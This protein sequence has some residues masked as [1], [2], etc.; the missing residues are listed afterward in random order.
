MGH[1]FLMNPF[2]KYRGIK[3]NGSFIP[4]AKIKAGDYPLP[5]NSN[6]AA[7]IQ[8]AEELFD[9]ADTIGVKTSGSTGDPKLFTFPKSALEQSAKATIS[10][11]NLLP[12]SRAALALPMDYIAAKMMVTR[13]VVGGFNIDVAQPSATPL[14]EGAQP[15]FIPV[16]PHQM[17]EIIA[18]QN[19]LLQRQTTFL[20]GGGPID[21]RLKA[22]L[23]ERQIT[24]YASFGMTE[25][26]SHFALAAINEEPLI[27]KPLPGVKIKQSEI[28]A[29]AVKWPGITGDWL[30]TNDLVEIRNGGFKWLGRSDFL[31]NSGG[32]KIIPEQ[33]ESEL[34][35]HLDS[36]FFIHGVPD[37]VLG[38]KAVLFIEGEKG[39][40][41]D[42]LDRV[43]WQS[44][45]H[46]PK[47][48]MYIPQF[49]RTE[50]GKIKRTE[51]VEAQR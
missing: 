13:A 17:Q 48:V 46:R 50:S 10:F 42:F 8:F 1:S 26:L 14:P 6:I 44:K 38:V 11:F 4:T 51:T 47:E 43:K 45:Y 12:Q 7:A 34:R 3:L 37:E 29:L 25:T 41:L 32:V 18:R 15:D 30:E 23:V 33:V 31:I 9:H 49:K 2:G 22:N 35:K 19:D 16:T 24:A 27:F 28:G 39:E 5:E 21:E 40:N 36:P 20:I